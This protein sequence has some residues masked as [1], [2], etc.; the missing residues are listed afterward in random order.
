MVFRRK[1]IYKRKY[2]RKG[3]RVRKFRVGS[4]NHH[5]FTRYAT[6]T[7]LITVSAGTAGQSFS[8]VNSLTAVANYTE[9]TN[10]YDQYKITGIK[11]TFQLEN[12][13]DASAILN[14]GAVANSN[15][16]FPRIWYYVDNN[17]S[18]A[19]ALIDCKQHVKVRHRVLRPNAM[20]TV[21]FKPAVLNQ[22]YQSALTSGYEAKTN[23]WI[24]TANSSVPHYGLKGFID[25]ML[26]NIQQDMLIR[27]EYK[28][29]LQ[30]KDVQ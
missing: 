13:P 7:D 4:T 29:Y 8:L 14:N 30:F 6:G 17:D 5:R 3:R 25:T 1:K 22:V 9:F 28:Y 18:T 26:I 2:V 10:L 15:N 11:A 27:V 21:F 23:Q 20:M 12:N 16:F 19:P 24:S